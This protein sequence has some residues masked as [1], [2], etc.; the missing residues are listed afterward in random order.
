MQITEI[1]QKTPGVSGGHACV[2]NTRIAVW[3]LASLRQQG[4]TEQELLKNYPG[5][6]LED[7]TA[8]WSYYYNNKSEID[9]LINSIED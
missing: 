7:L 6:S 5:L 2:R 3:T 1:I 9:F 4:A 8:V